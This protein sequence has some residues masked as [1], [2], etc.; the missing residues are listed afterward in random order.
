MDNVLNEEL[1]YYISMLSD[2][3]KQSVL[4]MLKTFTDEQSE[5]RIS[6]EQYNK[7]VDEALAQVERG[8]FVTLDELKNQMKSW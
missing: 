2:A 4:Q 7:E 6:V 1:H 5:G 8:E 3:Q